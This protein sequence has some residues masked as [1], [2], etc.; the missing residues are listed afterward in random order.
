MQPM[1]QNIIIFLSVIL[2][3]GCV[4]S[5]V[6]TPWERYTE[7]KHAVSSPKQLTVAE[8]R[9]NYAAPYPG[10]AAEQNTNGQIANIDY[11]KYPDNY[12]KLAPLEQSNQ[13]QT[14]QRQ[15]NYLYETQRGYVD[16]QSQ[17][18]Q[19][20]SPQRQQQMSPYQVSNQSAHSQPSQRPTLRTVKIALLLPLSGEHQDLGQAMLQSA[21]MA[22]FEMRLN[23]IELLPRDTVGTVEGARKAAQS[24][25]SSGAELIIGP[26]FSS[27]V[28][29]VKSITSRSNINMLTLSTD[30]SLAGGNVFIM[31]FLPFAQIERVAEYSLNNGIENIAILAPNTDYGNVVV[32]SY[33]SLAYRM[34]LNRAEVIKFPADE[35]DIS[36][37]IRS[38]TKYDERVQNLA[39]EV[40]LLE[41][42][43]VEFPEDELA[44]ERLKELEA[45]DTLGDVPFDAV[46][47]PI[48]GDKARSIANLLSFYDLGPE[49]VKRLGTGLWDDAGLATEQSMKSSWFAAP[50]PDNRKDFEKRYKQTYGSAAPRLSTLAYDATSLAAVLARNGLQ[51][52]G[53]PAFSRADFTNPNGFT[54]IDGIFR[55]RSDGLIE[56][57]LAVL[58]IGK[59]RVRVIDPAP[60]TFQQRYQK[61]QEYR[62]HVENQIIRDQRSAASKRNYAI[63]Y[64]DNMSEFLEQFDTPES[65]LKPW[66]IWQI[67][68]EAELDA[69]Q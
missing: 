67:N 25:I 63:P 54:G 28:K 4:T 42:Y 49:R 66:H 50:S 60:T 59:K 6:K 34:G 57:G 18:R 1:K 65:E 37:I 38:F 26:L 51:T 24:A 46:F 2:L 35:S 7:Q 19:Q 29:A 69:A 45:M 53:A 58:E 41:S 27:S 61:Q 68:K 55:F 5:G 62:K 32:A 20:I 9:Y 40:L 22:L 17:Q 13:R 15:N 8:D 10:S 36:N 39:E 44:I 31:G 43:L 21:Q 3:T 56:R 23:N 52:K 48:G 47:L 64:S 12:K 30:W 33:N 16:P 14:Y 11:K